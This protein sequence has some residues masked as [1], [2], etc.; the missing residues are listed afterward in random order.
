MPHLF[1]RILQP[2]TRQGCKVRCVLYDLEPSTSPNHIKQNGFGAID[3]AS[4]CSNCGW[5]WSS[6][7]T[8][9]PLTRAPAAWVGPARQRGARTHS[10]HLRTPPALPMDLVSCTAHVHKVWGCAAPKTPPPYSGGGSCPPNLPGWGAAAPQP[11]SG[12]F[13][14][15]I[16]RPIP[17]PSGHPSL[18]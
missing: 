13:G 10:T 11:P 14:A 4:F 15:P 12:A 9:R 7:H 5:P 17:R 8:C 18:F 16:S 2:I 6:L 1:R 3:V